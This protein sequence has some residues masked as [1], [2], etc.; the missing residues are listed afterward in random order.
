[1]SKPGGK[2]GSYRA[3][4]AAA[5]AAIEARR[6]AAGVTYQ[7]LSETSGVA[8]ATIRRMVRSGLGFQR[9]I[10]A[11]RMAMRTLERDR[12]SSSELFPS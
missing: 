2:R 3:E 6:I 7:A 11:L 1:M 9:K 8:V 5:I 10:N 4:E 12:R